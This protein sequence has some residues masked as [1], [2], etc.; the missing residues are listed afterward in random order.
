MGENRPDVGTA[1]ALLFLSHGRTPVTIARLQ[2]QK[3]T[4]T[5]AA[6]WNHHR[7]AIPNLVRHTSRQWGREVTSQT[8]DFS[9]WPHPSGG[10]MQEKTLLTV[11]DLLEF[12]VLFLSGSQ[13]L[14]LDA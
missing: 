12:P 11:A 4:I 10:T 14:D 3:G 7:H 1:F 13:A 9:R 6:D 8:I 2:H 5:D